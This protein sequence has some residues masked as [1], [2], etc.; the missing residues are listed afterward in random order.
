MTPQEYKTKWANES[1]PYG[2]FDDYVIFESLI[3]NNRFLLRPEE[4]NCLMTKLFDKWQQN[5]IDYMHVLKDWNE[6]LGAWS[7]GGTTLITDLPKFIEAIRLIDTTHNSERY[8]DMTSQDIGR[9]V[10]FLTNHQDEE[11]SIHCE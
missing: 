9:L 1:P 4:S 6:S 8:G 10:E 3:S 7:G 11:I 2:A 5:K